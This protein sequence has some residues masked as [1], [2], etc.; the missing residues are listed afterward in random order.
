[1]SRLVEYLMAA[2]LILIVGLFAL[3]SLL[4]LFGLR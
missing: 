1:M 2:A 3:G 4:L